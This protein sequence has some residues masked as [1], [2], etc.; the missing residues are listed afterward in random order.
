VF[1]WGQTWEVTEVYEYNPYGD[2]VGWYSVDPPDNVE[3]E[4]FTGQRKD[5][6]TGLD[7]FGAPYY[8]GGVMGVPG[9]LRWISA[10][11]VTTRA[12]DPPSL[13]KY[14][15]SRGDPVNLVDL[16]GRF[17]ICW[18]T[19]QLYIIDWFQGIGDW[20]ALEVDCIFFWYWDPPGSHAGGGGTAAPEPACFAQL[21]YRPIPGLPYNHSYWW[22]QDSSGDHWIVSAGPSER[23]IAV[24]TGYLNVDV[25]KGDKSSAR[26][27]DATRDPVAWSSG[28]SKE[29]CP[30][31][32]LLLAKA[33]AWPR[34]QVLYGGPLDPTS[35]S[36]ARYFGTL[37][38][39]GRIEPPP[40]T[41]GVGGWYTRIP[42]I[43]YRRRRFQ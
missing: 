34:D 15:Y 23:G 36:A 38:G 4:K 2:I 1:P 32:T 21:K 5:T 30:K 10:D 20:N 24:L 18:T 13:N 6:E 29:M 41:T 12:Y 7:Y 3:S 17:F 40:S 14:V 26:D 11:S 37:L 42:S 27:D 35:N 16:D 22:V 9:T 25:T 31:V 28:S 8:A 33:Q 19:Y 39:A 43:E